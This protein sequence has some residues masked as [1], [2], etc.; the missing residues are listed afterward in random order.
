[1][2]FSLVICMFGCLCYVLFGKEG[3]LGF[4]FLVYLFWDF[5]IVLIFRI[6]NVF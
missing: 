3:V 5:F 1:M 2:F 6:L 4:I